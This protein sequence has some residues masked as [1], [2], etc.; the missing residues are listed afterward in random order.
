VIAPFRRSRV[1]A[2]RAVRRSGEEIE[3]VATAAVPFSE[4]DIASLEV[5]AAR[6]R[7]TQVGADYRSGGATFRYEGKSGRTL[8]FAV[9][10]LMARRWFADRT[11]YYVEIEL[12]EGRRQ[13]MCGDMRRALEFVRRE[14]R[15]AEG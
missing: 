1:R 14:L 12:P 10:K 15:L 11:Y 7:C 9:A 2:Y 5:F 13:K 6:Y 4:V 3:G 8:G